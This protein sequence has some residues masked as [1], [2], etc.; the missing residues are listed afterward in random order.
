MFGK[1]LCRSSGIFSKKIDHSVNEFSKKPCAGSDQSTPMNKP[2]VE[3]IRNGPE[4]QKTK[5]TYSHVIKPHKT[6]NMNVLYSEVNKTRKLSPGIRET[7]DNYSKFT[8]GEYDRLNNFDRR[9]LEKD[10]NMY[11][12]NVGIR[13]YQD[14]MYD[15][16]LHASRF[17]SEDVYDHSFTNVNTDSNY[18][19][20]SSV[21]Q[22]HMKENDVYDKSV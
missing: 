7:D 10:S 4:M 14:P 9:I 19:C 3:N 15:T 6:E 13:N 2:H 20:S 11:D 1:S 5:D 12:S 16:T 21:A 17:E 8:E 18:D 22:T